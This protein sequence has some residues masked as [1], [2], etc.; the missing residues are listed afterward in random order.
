VADPT[1]SRSSASGA[2]RSCSPSSND[3]A[4]AGVEAP[5]L[6]DGLADFRKLKNY[7]YGTRRGLSP[8]RWCL[9][10]ESG[11]FLDPLYE[12]ARLPGRVELAG[13]ASDLREPDGEPEADFKRR[14]KAYTARNLGQFIG[15][16]PAFAGQY[17][18]FRD[19]V[20]TQAKV[21]WDNILTSCSRRPVPAGLQRGHELVAKVRDTFMP[22]HKMNI[23]MQKCFRALPDDCDRARRGFAVRRLHGRGALPG[24]NRR[25]TQGRGPS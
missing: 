2:T 1:T 19:G 12:P 16:G 17:E 21:M 4:A 25:L 3:G 9:T 15:W 5:V 10:G 23:Y 11:L 22:H 18:V 7:A 24:R 6:R 14:L 13:H 20:V 8:Q